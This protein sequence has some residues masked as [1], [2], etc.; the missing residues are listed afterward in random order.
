[1]KQLK[2]V[3]INGK[4]YSISGDNVFVRYSA[5]ADGTDFTEK[6]NEGQKY[7]GIATGQVAPT[8]K[9]AYDWLPMGYEKEEDDRISE[10]ET[11]MDN[12][13]NAL[14]GEKAGNS[15][16][17]DDISPI[18]APV[19]VSVESKNIVPLVYDAGKQ[20]TIRGV[21]FTVNAD[22]SITL[23]GTYDGTGDASFFLVRRDANN[24]FII[25]KGTYIGSTGIANVNLSCKILNGAY[26][27]LMSPN[28]F[29]QDTPL[30]MVYVSMMK[31]YIGS[32]RVFNGETVYPMI[33]RGTVSEEFTSPVESGTAVD[34]VCG[35][36]RITSSVGETIE[37][38]NIPQGST[39]TAEHEGVALHA[40]YNKDINKA[41]AELYQ[42][43][44]SLGGNV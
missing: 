32:D 25:K 12:T 19:K 30:D 42:A 28:T 1:M 11:K 37:V 17:F 2:D 16:I 10:L 31:Q 24:P 21:T 36:D 41:F 5:Y 35:D 43:F 39:I 20:A 40:E 8:S 34:V 3:R 22:G 4:K 18:S 6:L 27:S 9:D 38:T 33:M 26:G 29:H 44:I 23:T 15:I 7:L 14:I 13:A